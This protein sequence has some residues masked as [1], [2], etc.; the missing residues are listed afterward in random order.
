MRDT[1]RKM[2]HLKDRFGFFLFVTLVQP[3]GSG[4]SC[5][6]IPGLY[7]VYPHAR[8]RFG[9]LVGMS[10]DLFD[11]WQVFHLFKL[12]KLVILASFQDLPS[13]YLIVSVYALGIWSRVVSIGFHDKNFSLTLWLVM[14]SDLLTG[15]GPYFWPGGASSWFIVSLILS[16]LR[17]LVSLWEWVLALCAWILIS[18]SW[19]MWFVLGLP[20]CYAFYEEWPL[21]YRSFFHVRIDHHIYWVTFKAY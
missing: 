4:I 15:L 2:S 1:G 11:F 14:H 7:Y 16:Y 5:H 21:C 17:Y 9:T 18:G 19:G 10:A 13:S 20:V 12:V 6:W 8:S 3:S